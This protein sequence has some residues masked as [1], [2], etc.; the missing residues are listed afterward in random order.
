ASRCAWG[1]LTMGVFWATEVMP[2]AATAL[3]PVFLFPLTSVSTTKD[4][5]DAYFNQSNMLFLAGLMIAIAVEDSNLHKR[6][7]LRIVLWTGTTLRWVLLGFMCCTCFLSVWISNTATTAMMV[8]IVEAVLEERIIVPRNIS[9]DPVAVLDVDAST[10]DLFEKA[11]ESETIS[12]S[13]INEVSKQPREHDKKTEKM[14]QNARIG[15]LFAVAYSANLGGTGAI[16]S[17][18]PNLV[19]MGILDN[20]YGKTDLNFATWMAFNIPGMLLNLF[21]AWIWLQMIFIGLPLPFKRSKP[22][23]GSSNISENDLEQIEPNTDDESKRIGAVLRQKFDALGPISFAEMT[24]GIS[25]IVLI[26]LW[27]LREPGFIRGWSDIFS[28]SVSDATPAILIVAFLFA[29]PAK[30]D[31]GF[32]KASGARRKPSHRKLLEWRS[33]HDKLAWNVIILLGGGFAMSKACTTSGLA[34]WIGDTLALLSSLQPPVVL[35]ILT[36][37]TAFMTEL[38]SNTATAAILLPAIPDLAT[39]LGVH[40]LYLMLPLTVTCS[41]AFMLPIATPP[42]AIV[43]AVLHSKPHIMGGTGL[44]M[45]LICILVLNLL[46]NC[47]GPLVFNLNPTGLSPIQRNETS[48][49]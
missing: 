4:I 47:Y 14:L 26:I 46:M 19:L 18:A 17:T 16:T 5:C 12:M 43:H 9:Q 2:L 30:P 48:F 3:L 49:T 24:T 11:T 1:M 40:P 44:I 28:V 13:E 32:C 39:K 36:T 37:A 41:Y 27:V 35:L 33:V 23:S 25:F 38:V 45:N 29:T 6:I 34:N 42:N 15:C 8:P 7:A 21:I 31:F 20:L 22:T 10:N